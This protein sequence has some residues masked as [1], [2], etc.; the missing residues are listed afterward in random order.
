ME[1]VMETIKKMRGTLALAA[2]NLSVFMWIYFNAD[3]TDGTQWWL[4]L[5]NNGA[6]YNPFTLKDEW[7]RLF[8]SMFLHGNWLHIA[9]NTYGLITVGLELEAHVGTRKF[10]LAYFLGGL[11]GGLCSLYFNLFVLGVGASGAVFALFGYALIVDIR[12]NRQEGYSIVPLILNF[13]VFLAINFVIS[14]QLSGD[15]FAHFGGVMGGILLAS[16]SI[17]NRRWLPEILVLVLLVLGFFALPRFQV[18]YFNF[19]QQVLAAQDSTSYVLN[20]SGSK[21]NEQFLKDYKRVNTK[22]DSA[23][24]MLDAQEY[25]PVELAPD[26]FKLRRFIRYHKAEGDY[27]IV[28]IENESYIYADSIDIVNDSIR[29]YTGLQY[30]LNLNYSPPPDS[31]D[32]PKGPELSIAKVWYDSNWVEI[33]FPP[34]E[35]FRVGRKDTAGL[36]Q[37]PLIDYYKNGNPQ[38]K[39]SYKDDIKDGIFIYYTEKGGYSAAG[40]YNNDQRIG[41]WETFHANG[42]IESEVYYRDRYFLKSYW[43]STGTQ[44]VK[45]GYGREQH[46]YPSGIIAAEGEY[47]DGYQEGY[48]YGRH[49][50]GQMY[51]EENYNH[52][53][54]V[55]GR[56]RSKNGRVVVYDESTLYALPEGGYKKLNDY[57][58]SS[59]KQPMGLGTVKLSFRVTVSGQITDFKIEQS[60]SK[61]LDM[62]AKQIILSGPRWLP[63]RLHGVEPT[64]GFG[65]VAIEF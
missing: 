36:W 31:T 4:T 54:L 1:F 49:A 40:I 11:A 37:G 8:T 53:R 39:G 27:R 12:R 56:S 57:L 65:F 30:V 14:E 2:A 18:H 9:L 25:L 32:Q 15:H 3:V 59:I 13:C 46:R 22:W 21:S 61:E 26:T 60:V 41:K 52:G 10:L 38:M 29:K 19:F 45:D 42:R 7:Y 64:D 47:V 20:N 48:W 44:M 6:L 62:R 33:P 51:F 55:N 35:F 63:A 23:L 24:N 28:M 50:D 16:L 17:F 43:D 5:L 34:A 58:K